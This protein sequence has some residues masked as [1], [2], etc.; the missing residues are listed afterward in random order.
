MCV[1]I[2][3]LNSGRL[4]Y[5]VVGLHKYPTYLYYS[6]NYQNVDDKIYLE[7]LS[8]SVLEVLSDSQVQ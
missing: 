1:L 6:E 4:L 3:K 2:P 8:D 7:V 5:M